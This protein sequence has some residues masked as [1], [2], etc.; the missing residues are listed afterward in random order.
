MRREVKRD[1]FPFGMLRGASGRKIRQYA[2]T[3]LV[4]LTL[5]SL[6]YGLINKVYLYKVFSQTSADDAKEFVEVESMTREYLPIYRL[7]LSVKEISRFSHQRAC[8]LN[9]VKHTTVKACRFESPIIVLI[10]GESYNRHHA[11][12]YGYGLPTTPI[13]QRLYDEGQLFRFDDVATSYNLTFKSFQNM[14]TLYDYDARGHWYDYPVVPSLFRKAGYKVGFFSNQNTLDK[15]SA[16]TDYSE[17][18]F[19][20][21]TELSKFMFDVR[22]TESHRYDMSLTNDYLS[23][24]GVRGRDSAQLVIFHFIGIHADYRFRYPEGDGVFSAADYHRPDLTDEELGILSDYDNAIRYNDKVIGAIVDLFADKDAVIIHLADHGELVYDDGHE[25]GRNFTLQRKNIIP[26]FDIPFW[27]YCS[28]AYKAHHPTIC[29]QIA[30]AVGRPFMT[31]DLPHLLLYLAGIECDG[32]QP[33]RNLIDDRFN[34]KRKR[35]IMGDT[36]YDSIMDN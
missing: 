34:M 28:D 3:A 31:D 16:F 1:G 5:I 4:V 6:G 10:I 17:D 33:E 25:M 21:N 18:V 26:Q 22:N 12:L 27:I 35:L 14:L 29:R 13:Q 11:S 30:G 7:A 32:Y 36:D 2:G 20:N 23:M 15:K 19:M 8:L 9:N 24:M